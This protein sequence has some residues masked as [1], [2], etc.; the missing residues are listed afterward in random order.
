MAFS[1]ALLSKIN[2]IQA[3]DCLNWGSNPFFGIFIIVTLYNNKT[4]IRLIGKYS[5][6][7]SRHDL[8]QP[9]RSRHITLEHKCPER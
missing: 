1:E 9:P 7:D 4:R 5:V 6:H 8:R 2:V 3:V